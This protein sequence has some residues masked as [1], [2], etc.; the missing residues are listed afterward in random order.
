MANEQNSAS[1]NSA[2]D[3]AARSSDTIIVGCKLPHGYIMEMIPKPNEN[4]QAPP[5][6]ERIRL[7]GA[8]SVPSDS[9]IHVNPRILGYGR[10]TVSRHFWESWL[11]MTKERNGGRDIEVVAKGFIFAEPKEAD[12]RAHARDGLPEA[13]GLE[14]LNPIAKNEPRLKT[15]A[16]NG[17]PETMIEGDAEHLKRLQ[18]SLDRVA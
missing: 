3:Q 18:N 1:R 8:N 4:F 10:T 15:L 14:G 17:H 5:A 7:N 9:P 12:F 6:G 13:T 16:K 2:N 11:A